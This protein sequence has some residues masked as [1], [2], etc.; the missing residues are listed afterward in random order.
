MENENIDLENT[1]VSENNTVDNNISNTVDENISTNITN[2]IENTLNETINNTTEDET[3][4]N[5]V[6]DEDTVTL[7]TIHED[8]IFIGSILIFFVIVI[9]VQVILK[10]FKIFF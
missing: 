5:I 7:H 8:I 9:L 10:F 3:I 1:I 4:S 6:V 2:I